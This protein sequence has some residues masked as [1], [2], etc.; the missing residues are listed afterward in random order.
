[1]SLPAPA[2]EPISAAQA[3]AFEQQLAMVTAERDRFA[4]ERDEY[5][6]RA[7]WLHQQLE[8]LKYDARTPR[9]RVDPRQIQLV[10]DPFAQAL[11]AVAGSGASSDAAPEPASP[12]GGDKPGKKKRNTTPH[13]RRVLP[14]HLPV[15][16]LVL[17]P[18]P[19]PDDAIQI[20][21][22]VSW[23]LGYR[24]ASYYRLR[25]VRPL[26]VVSK[27]AADKSSEV[28]ATFF[29]GGAPP[30]ALANHS[31]STPAAS[32]PGDYIATDAAATEPTGTPLQAPAPSM[33]SGESG[34]GAPVATSSEH[35]AM[36]AGPEEQGS[37]GRDAVAHDLLDKT[38]VVAPAPDEIIARGLPT[39][40]LLAHVLVG[41]FADKLPFNRQEG[42][43]ARQG[44]PITRGTMCGWAKGAHELAHHVV[45]AMVADSQKYADVIATD[46]TGVLV[47]ANDQCKHGHFWVYVADRDHVVFRYS[48]TH[49]N[50]EPKSF[51]KGF[52]GT[53]L[54]DASNV[55]DVLFGLPD[56]PGEANCWSHARRYFYKAIDSDSRDKALI[57]VGFCNELFALERQ[58]KKLPP[59]KRLE[60]RRQRSAPVI[61][62]LRRWKDEELANP[63][64]AEGSRLRKAL[65]YL[66]NQWPALSKFLED[67]R[68]PI[69]NNESERQLRSLVVGRANWVFVGSDDTAAWTCTFVSLMASCELHG[70][71]PEG[72]LRDLFRVLP[73]WPKNRMLELAPKYWRATRALLDEAELALPLG[74][75][76]VP[77]ARALREAAVTAPSP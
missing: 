46:A 42:I 41:K 11:L 73:V 67:G 47:Q 74:P 24:R 27:G 3:A 49:C 13:G 52:H 29:G 43:A 28:A 4:Q 60:M 16:T 25:V 9:E 63:H 19:L 8:R 76:R 22:E 14:E 57:G 53:V 15:E 12:E 72:Y 66:T 10:F 62:M 30:A 21:A 32:A 33:T 17:T 44:V 61:E 26:L 39:P 69:H 2:L 59:S 51:F 50:D 35:R 38:I 6:N 77:P 71:D 55:Y 1:M 45:D 40:D 37:A 70:I 58:W 64:V 20:G 34:D 18:S 23:R 56:S 36:S 75:F 68:V 31:Q 5:K 7:E 65:N 54:S 48:P